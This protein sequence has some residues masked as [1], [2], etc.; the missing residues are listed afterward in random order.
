[1]LR[2]IQYLL[3]VL[4]VLIIQQS[5]NNV[6]AINFENNECNHYSDYS[7][8]YMNSNCRYNPNILSNTVS[9]P[10]PINIIIQYFD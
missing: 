2:L 4:I 7:S 1:M 10:V 5:K 9:I 6:E 8:W 3:V